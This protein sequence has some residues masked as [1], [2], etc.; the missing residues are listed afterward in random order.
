MPS[1]T[2]WSTTT[3][4]D[5]HAVAAAELDHEVSAETGLSRLAL[6]RVA[7]FHDQMCREDACQLLLNRC[8]EHWELAIEGEGVVRRGPA[9]TGTPRA[10][11]RVFARM[12]V[13]DG[14]RAVS[15]GGAAI[16]AERSG[17]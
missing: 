6:E 12:T 9:A 13:D 3:V 16:G 8:F 2:P 15:E 7:A 11:R 5:D 4:V 14:P 1:S 17:P 10:P